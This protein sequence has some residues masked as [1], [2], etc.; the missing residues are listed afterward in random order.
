M[1][2]FALQPMLRLDFETKKNIAAE[3]PGC[4]DKI[5]RRGGEL[6]ACDL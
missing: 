4:H 1:S 5:C 6:M 2:S 3:I